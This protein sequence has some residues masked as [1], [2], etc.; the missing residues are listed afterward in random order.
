[1]RKERNDT[2]ARI[3]EVTRAVFNRWGYEGMTL[4][5]VAKGVGIEVQSLY[6]YTPSKQALVERIVRTG[7]SELQRSVLEALETAPEGAREQLRAAVRAHVVYYASSQYVV[8]F[9]RNSLIHF[10]EE[11][12]ESLLK[13]LKGYEQIFK[14]IIHRGIE[15]GEFSDVEVTP[16]TYAMLGMGES[17]TNWWHPSGSLDAGQLGDLYAEL[18]LR[19]VTDPAPQTHT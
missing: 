6:N 12:R 17:I 8:A 1:M 7:T 18:A 2:E 10:D 3:L 5:Q 13:E 4:R 16:V 9:F 11:T 19:M 14:E 15:T